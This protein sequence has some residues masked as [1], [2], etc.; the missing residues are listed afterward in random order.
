MPSLFPHSIQNPGMQRQSGD[1][2]SCVQLLKYQLQDLQT[3][4]IT[5]LRHASHNPPWDFKQNKT[6]DERLIK[7]QN[8]WRVQLAVQLPRSALHQRKVCKKCMLFFLSPGG[9]G[10]MSRT[11]AVPQLAHNHSSIP[12]LPPAPAPP[13]TSL[14]KVHLVCSADHWGGV[15][16]FSLSCSLPL[17][18]SN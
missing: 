2:G 14:R 8:K 1:P 16:D 18:I 9:G 4:L 5:D 17:Q 13:Q 7:P 6:Q 12:N 3:S 11:R 10:S 15:W